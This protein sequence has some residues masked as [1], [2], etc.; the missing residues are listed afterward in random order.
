MFLAIQFTGDSS[1]SFTSVVRLTQDVNFG[2]IL[3]TL[4]ANGASAF[5]ICLFMHTGR[6]VYYHSYG[7]RK[8]WLSG[9]SMFLL[10]IAAAFLGY[11]LPWGQ[12][13]FWGASVITSLIQAVPYLGSDIVT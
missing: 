8:V 11:V 10:V 4:H 5:F 9:V 1:L 12:I 3:R 7:H 6:G 2:W 13:S